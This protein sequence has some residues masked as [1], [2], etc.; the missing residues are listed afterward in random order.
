[1][2]EQIA[3]LRDEAQQEIEQVTELTALQQCRVTYLG[4]KGKLTQVMRAL[5][6]LPATDRP[7][8]GQLA[9]DVR[10]HIEQAIDRKEQQLLHAQTQRRLATETI[11]VTFPGRKRYGGTIHPLRQIIEEIEDIFLGLGFTI[12]EGPEVETDYYNFEALNLPVDHPARDMQDSF[13]MSSDLLLRTQT[14]PVQVRTL[15]QRQGEVPVKIICPGKVYR[16]DDDDPTH[17]HQFMQIEGLVVDT[18]VRM[19]DLRG[20]LLHFA[21]QMFGHDTHMRMRPSFFPF[22][23]PSVEID[24]TCSVCHG[25]G[26]R[27]CKHSGWI[28]ILGAGMVHAHVLDH[29]GYDPT[30]VRGFA[31]GLGVERIAM[32]RYGIEDIRH[33]YTNDLLFLQQFTRR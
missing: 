6:S 16:R 3:Q 12:A 10:V 1:M 2:R 20:T 9:N 14:S 26:C 23:Q 7:Y 21:R 30:R 13:Y 19:S 15:Q 8:I 29:S 17:S 33:F 18:D 31:F 5:V 28:E 4:K 11:D 25:E 22:T 27:V 32:L 24:V